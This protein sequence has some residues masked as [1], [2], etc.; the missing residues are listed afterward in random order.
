MARDPF[1]TRDFDRVEGLPRRIIDPEAAAKLGEDLTRAIARPSG[2]M[3]LNGIQGQALYEAA[4]C[5]GLFG[6]L[7]VGSGK[8]LISLLAPYVIECRKPLLL[9]PAA[10]RG[11]TEKDRKDLARHFPVARN[12]LVVSYEELGRVGASTLLDRYQPDLIVADEVHKLKNR[13]AAVT[14]RV[15]RYM[16]Q[17]PETR[18]VAL[19]GTVVK[20]SLTDFAHILRWCLKD[21]APVPK[22]VEETGEWAQ[23][24]D[25]KDW[26]TVAPG[27][28]DRT[29]RGSYDEAR[30]GFQQRLT[31]TPGVLIKD[32]P[33]VN[34]SLVIRGLTYDVGPETEANFKRLRD[35]WEAPTGWTISEAV[36]H[37]AM[38]RQLALGLHYEFSPLAPEDW[39]A[40][41]KAW[42]Q[43][44]RATL[45]RSRTYDTELQIR[46]AVDSRHVKDNGELYRWEAIK[47]TFTPN[48]VPVWHDTAGLDVCARWAASGPGIVFTSHAFFGR[49]L[50]KRLACPYYGQEGKDDKGR[51]IETED[52]SRVIVASAQANGTGRNL[53]M[54]SRALVTAWQAGPDGSEQL[55]GRLHRQG[56]DADE[57]VFDVLMGCREHVQGFADCLAG[58]EANGDL[59]GV[60]YRI[61]I[62]DKIDI[63]DLDALPKTPR[64]ARAS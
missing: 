37:W 3:V 46:Q 7:G 30:K 21:G 8:T 63:P 62:A 5:G 1:L 19:S 36:M 64:W 53:Q 20:R 40:A 10:L 17:R 6:G 31:S 52:G 18:F 9:I 47:H 43:F 14:R 15:E 61:R 11:K 48:S 22:T 4:E 51:A 26:P 39:L 23:V 56:Q 2:T 38:A 44:V 29:G 41:R 13:R 49:A 35:L 57:V 54:F 32:S 33:E 12:M 24:L 59:I 27:R 45:A 28:L 55:L 42:A 34:A 25:V 60:S 58:S 50:A 16:H